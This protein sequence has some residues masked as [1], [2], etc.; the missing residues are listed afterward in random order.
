MGDEFLIFQS[1]VER[2]E[3][4]HE[5]RRRE[6]RREMELIELGRGPEGEGE[7]CQ[8]QSRAKGLLTIRLKSMQFT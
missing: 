1:L 4:L 6:L 3:L 2:L 7:G 5:L 8:G